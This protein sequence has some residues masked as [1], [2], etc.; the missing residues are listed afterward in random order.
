[1]KTM[2]TRNGI[3]QRSRTLDDFNRIK[4][5]VYDT[6]DEIMGEAIPLLME[7]FKVEFKLK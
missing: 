3:N 1:M 5:F 4:G 7:E 6:I 2:V